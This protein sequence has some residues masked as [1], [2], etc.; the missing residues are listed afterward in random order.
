M[1]RRRTVVPANGSLISVSAMVAGSI[2]TRQGRPLHAN[3]G[4]PSASI[5]MPYGFELGVDNVTSLMSPVAG[6]RRPTMLLFCRVNH[7]IPCLSKTAVCGSFA[8]GSGIL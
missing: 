7:M 4:T 6:S 3:Q 2:L 5:L 1:S 8:A